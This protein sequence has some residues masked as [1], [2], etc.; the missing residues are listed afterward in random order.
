MYCSSFFLV[1]SSQVRLC[2]VIPVWPPIMRTATSKAPNPVPPTLMPVLWWW[3][4]T[5]SPTVTV[6]TT[7]FVSACVSV[8]V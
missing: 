4:I 2:N 3:A 8:C 1:Y 7:L 5:V 6:V